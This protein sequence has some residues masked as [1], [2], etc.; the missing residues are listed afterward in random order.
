MLKNHRSEQAKMLTEH[1]SICV[2]SP[3]KMKVS[4]FL[5]SE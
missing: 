2:K 1:E 5:I 3:D 4:N